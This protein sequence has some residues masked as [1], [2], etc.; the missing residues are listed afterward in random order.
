[1]LPILI[2]YFEGTIRPLL[3]R[4]AR[5]WPQDAGLAIGL[6]AGRC[7]QI[8]IGDDITLFGRDRRSSPDGPNPRMLERWS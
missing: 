4:S 6:D 8:F 3:R 5:N 2:Q 7:N 1:M